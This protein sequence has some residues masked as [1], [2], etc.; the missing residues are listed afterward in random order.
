MTWY[1]FEGDE[2]KRDHKIIFSFSVSCWK[3]CSK[4]DMIFKVKL[5]QCGAKQPPNYP[6]DSTKIDC[7]LTT[8]MTGIDCSLLK[9][10]SSPNGSIYY[11]LPLDLAVTLQAA[12]AVMKFSSEVDGKETG[13]VEASY[14]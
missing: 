10:Y 12:S 2:L 11:K 13:S 9:E 3:D 6:D 1:I 8:N 7:T 4:D 5:I 14:E